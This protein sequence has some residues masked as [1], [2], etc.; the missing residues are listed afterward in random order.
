[1]SIRATILICTLSMY[2]SSYASDADSIEEV[3]SDIASYIA[4]G[5]RSAFDQGAYADRLE[6]REKNEVIKQISDHHATC[7]VEAY[8]RLANE[9]SVKLEEV[10][11]GPQKGLIY[12]NLFSG[13]EIN[14]RTRNCVRYAFDSA[15]IKYD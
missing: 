12:S 9:H 3:I 4:D 7:L 14:E 1:M 15:G 5:L 2:M 10:F 8:V 11:V 6:G 13:E